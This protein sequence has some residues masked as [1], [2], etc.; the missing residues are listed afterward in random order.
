M[1]VDFRWS[2]RLARLLDGLPY[3]VW[4]PS[5]ISRLRRNA[6]AILIHGHQQRSLQI[7]SNDH[8]SNEFWSS[9]FADHIRSPTTFFARPLHDARSCR[10]NATMIGS[11]SPR[12]DQRVLWIS[13]AIRN[14]PHAA[15]VLAKTLSLQL[16]SR[17]LVARSLSRCRF[18]RNNVGIDRLTMPHLLRLAAA[19]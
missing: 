19:R 8:S 5:C 6:S 17:V 9:P 14:P 3:R 15:P 13:A 12:S 10:R 16:S 4:L 1:D 2:A 18:L 11:E 7:K